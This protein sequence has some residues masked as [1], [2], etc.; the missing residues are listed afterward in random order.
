MNTRTTRGGS[1]NDEGTWKRSEDASATKYVT[2]TAE[3]RVIANHKVCRESVGFLGT[4]LA[5]FHQQ[6]MGGGATQGSLGSTRP[7]QDWPG[8]KS[9]SGRLPIAIPT[10]RR[11]LMTLLGSFY[12]ILSDYYVCFQLSILV[13]S[14][15]QVSRIQT[16]PGRNATVRPS[17]AAA[18]SKTPL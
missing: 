12:G 3:T 18:E 16:S 8:A 2:M 10:H 7:G 5:S 11:R 13:E 4:N 17:K 15:T 1:P 6:G 9:S 14:H